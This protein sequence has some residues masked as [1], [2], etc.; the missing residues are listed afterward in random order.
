MN[1]S[2]EYFVPVETSIHDYLMLDLE[3]FQSGFKVDIVVDNNDQQVAFETAE[4]QY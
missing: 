3:Y 4:T 2:F 1:F